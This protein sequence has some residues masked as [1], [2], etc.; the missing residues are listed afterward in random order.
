[1]D[2]QKPRPDDKPPRPSGAESARLRE[3]IDSGATGDKVP[4][5]DPSAA[6]LGTDAEAGGAP[7]AAPEVRRIQ[8]RELSRR[9]LRALVVKLGGG[10]KDGRAHRPTTRLLPATVSAFSTLL[11]PLHPFSISGAHLSAS[12]P[13]LLILVRRA[14]AEAPLVL[15]DEARACSSS[16]R[17]PPCCR[18]LA[19]LPG[20]CCCLACLAAACGSLAARR[21]A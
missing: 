10:T 9:Q 11:H 19:C 6:P 4:F 15:I 8:L 1:M 12:K 17:P 2:D 13:Q 3:D 21:R 16:P 7:A 5:S 14:M 20:C 18:L